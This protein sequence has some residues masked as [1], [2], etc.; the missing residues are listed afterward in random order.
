MKSLVQ[1][2]REFAIEKKQEFFKICFKQY[3]QLQNLP[4][5]VDANIFNEETQCIVTLMSQ[6]LG[7]DTDKYINE[8][9]M[10]LLFSLST[11]QVDFVE[12]NQ[13]LKT[14]CLKFDEFLAGNIHS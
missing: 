3:V 4:F 14:S 7:L 2:F 10:S 9:L 1:Y 6:F 5:H 8:P 11:F 12:S 13:L